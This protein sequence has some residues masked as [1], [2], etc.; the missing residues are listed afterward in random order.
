M[1]TVQGPTRTRASHEDKTMVRNL[2]IVIALVTVSGAAS[3]Q[4]GPNYN[5]GGMPHTAAEERAC[6][7]DA[8][9]LCK[10]ALGDDFRVGSCLQDHRERLSRACRALLDGH[11]M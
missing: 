4:S 1:L 6:S 5:P 7:G 9:R 8:H 10:D 3:A 2:C 11:N